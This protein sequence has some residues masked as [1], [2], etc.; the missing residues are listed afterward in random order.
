M[1]LRSAAMESSLRHYTNVAPGEVATDLLMDEEA[2]AGFYRNTV[3]PFWSYLARVSGSE[4]LA[5]DLVQESYLRFL[6]ARAPWRDG[7]VACRRYLFRIGTNLLRDHWRRPVAA[8]L[9]GVPERELPVVGP[10]EIEGLDSESL[11]NAAMAR[12]RPSERQLLWL[13]HAEGMSY[14]EISGVTGFGVARIRLALFRSRRKLARL[15]R[16]Q[17]IKPGAR[18]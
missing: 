3:R 16:H 8:P 18:K 10:L 11:L 12:L 4:T 14:R 9:D 1:K 17:S 13:A 6:C 2:F 7:E 15:L 5:D